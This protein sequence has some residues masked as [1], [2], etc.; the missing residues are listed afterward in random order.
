MTESFVSDANPPTGELE[1]KAQMRER[2]L[3]DYVE[4][5]YRQVDGWLLD[6]AV[7][8][9]VALGDQQR[10]L[11]I[12]GNVAEIGVHH[13]KLFILLQLM[14]QEN[15]SAV[16]ID[17]F[18][19]QQKNV[20]GSGHG[21]RRHLLRNLKRFSDL[22]RTV[23]HNGDSA[24]LNSEALTRL[25]GG[26]FRIISIDGGHTAD[27]TYHDLQTAE[28][29]IC[30]S[31]III[32]DD[33]FN[34]M[35]PGVCDGT[36]RFFQTPRAIVPFAIGGNKTMLC[37]PEYRNVYTEAVR[38]VSPSFVIRSFLGRE[39][40]CCNFLPLSLTQKIGRTAAWQGI[41]KFAL[42]KM[43]TSVVKSFFFAIR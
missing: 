22:G 13:G 43:A 40:L 41:K 11:S 16:A 9:I 10:K 18:E 31:G 1:S 3:R 26:D 30:S 28:G 37:R 42:V 15:E 20:D 33:C 6:A 36:H 38:N 2:Q 19:N 24:E 23:I 8:M 17:V 12:S 29:A 5:R 39:V 21:D 14:A 27:L 35:W 4:R 25:G 7:K 32:L 34:E